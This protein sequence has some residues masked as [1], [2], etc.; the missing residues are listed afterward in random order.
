[1]AQTGWAKAFMIFFLVML[2]LGF[3][4]PLINLGNEVPP[5]A[6]PRLCQ[7]DSDCY[8]MCDTPVSVLCS[9]NLCQQNACDELQLYPFGESRVF[10]LRLF[11]EQ[12]RIQLSN[13]DKDVF[14]TFS[15]EEVR[16]FT[17]GLT[18]GQILEKAAIRFTP[19]CFRVNGQD[20]CQSDTANV[21]M[22]VNGNSSYQ[23]NDYVPENGDLIELRYS[24]SE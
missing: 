6:E 7:T 11:V 19:N 8:L 9:Q 16:T 22:M 12:K 4:V 23:Y 17:S 3:S 14:V 2:V 21:T 18:L 24:S 5:A 20:Y 15:D 1:M 13:S 10:Q